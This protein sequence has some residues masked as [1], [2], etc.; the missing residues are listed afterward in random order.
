GPSTGTPTSPFGLE[1]PHSRRG[2]VIGNRHIPDL[3]RS[4]DVEVAHQRLELRESRNR[5][6]PQAE[7]AS[8]RAEIGAAEDCLPIVEAVLAQLVGL[9]PIGAVIKHAYQ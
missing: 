5:R 2:D 7:T 6:P 3:R 9:R 8:D 1:P 4:L